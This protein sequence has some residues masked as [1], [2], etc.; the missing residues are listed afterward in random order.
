MTSNIDVCNGRAT[1]LGLKN[2]IENFFLKFLEPSFLSGVKGA[3]V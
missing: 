3:C 2:M 1:A